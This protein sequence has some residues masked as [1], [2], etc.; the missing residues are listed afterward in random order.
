[1]P[2]ITYNGET[3]PDPATFA[4][5]Y[6]EMPKTR[7]DDQSI[8]VHVMNASLTPLDAQARQKEKENNM[9]LLVQVSGV[10]KLHDRS[11]APRGFSDSFVLVPNKEVGK[12]KGRGQSWA[13]Q[14]Q[15]FRLV[16]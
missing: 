11:E 13:V 4:A 6:A 2:R 10:L 12:D 7:L 16:T 14:S 8:N 1:M 5:R 15:N 9:S 3:M